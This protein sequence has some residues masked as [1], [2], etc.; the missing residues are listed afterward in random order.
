MRYF[1]NLLW[2]AVL[3][4]IAL[5]AEANIADWTG[6]YSMNHDGHA[7]KLSILDTGRPCRG[8]QWCQLRMSYA[9]ANGAVLPARI[10]SMDQGWQHMVFA[11]YFPGSPQ[12][13]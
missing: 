10:I 13:F 4:P 5:L 12:R 11:V 3:C 7:G 8:V 9:D 2:L 1:Q 6:E